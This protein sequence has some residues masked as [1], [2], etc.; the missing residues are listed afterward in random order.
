MVHIFTLQ[1]KKR[2]ENHPETELRRSAM[3]KVPI[4]ELLEGAIACIC[5][6][7][8]WETTGFFMF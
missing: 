3:P 4:K 2:V 5:H 1:G 8:D 6:G 7:E